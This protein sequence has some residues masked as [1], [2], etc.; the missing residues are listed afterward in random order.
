MR[1]FSLFMRLFTC[2]CLLAFFS[3]SPPLASSSIPEGKDPEAL[4]KSLARI[5]FDLQHVLSVR[6][7]SL[8]RDPFTITFDRGH[9]IFL[10]PVDDLVTGLYF[11]GSGMIVGIPPTKTERQQLNVFT[12]APVLNEHFHEALIRFSDNTYSELMGQLETGSNSLESQLNLS[13]ELLQAALKG[14]SLT[15]YRIV[16]DL[17][18]GRKAPLFL[19]KIFGARLGAFDFS[20]DWRKPESVSLGQVHRT[21]GLLYYDSWGS[22]WQGVLRPDLSSRPRPDLSVRPRE[23]KTIDVL[24]YQIDTQIDKQ[25]RI[26]GSTEVEFKPEQEG[27]WLLS[28][29]LARSLKVSEVMD[30]EQRALTFYQN[31][32]MSNEEEVSKLGHD[33]I[34][35]LLKRPLQ[36]G[37]IRRLKF[38]YSGE[39]LSRMGNGVFYVGA[40]GSWYPNTGLS[41]RARYVLSFQYPKAYTIVATGDFT[42]EWEEGD[43]RHALWESRSEL[44]VAGFNYGDYVKKTA[45]AGRIPVEVYANRGIENVY[46]EVMARQEQIR[47][48]YRQ[49]QAS[50]RLGGEPLQGFTAAAPDFSDFDTTR[51]SDEVT[52]QVVRAL[53]FF[54]PILG[55]FPFSRL[56]VSQIPGKFSQG[57][58][59]LLYVSSLSFLRPEQRE[60]LGIGNDQEANFLECLHAHEIAH[61]WWGNQVSWKSYHDLWMFEGFSNYLAYLFMKEKHPDG[62]QFRDLMRSSK[63]KLL[64]KNS[65]GQTYESAGSLWLGT[66]LSSS[67]FPDG[68]SNLIYNKGAWVL[69]MLRYLMQDP[70][71]GSDQNFH[72]LMRNFLATYRGQS[73]STEDFKRMIEENMEKRMDLEGNGKMDWFFSQWV[74]ETGMPTYRLE[75]SLT[76]LKTGQF[77]LKGKI[78]QQNVSEDFVMPVELFGR[79]GPNRV[80]RLA[81]VVVFGNETNFRFTMKAR[82]QK[83]TLDENNE[84]LCENKTL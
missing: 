64:I 9:M 35:V 6:D 72:L 79:F 53:L 13:S 60:R 37:Q 55:D 36:R 23:D 17:M 26:S 24:S 76:T 33:V 66:R 3:L 56:A 73:V 10:R 46:L 70:N 1:P 77:L 32:D 71:S 44:S 40:R 69:H 51:F 31:S 27:E 82:P 48:F 11:W 39:V 5:E 62:K 2:S 75:S 34:L 57:W 16:A 63:E 83:V 81:R 54:E 22:F 61:Q 7:L 65:E 43:Q 42:K 67:K 59:S 15:H 38:L 19:A 41:D 45:L 4:L 80:E 68:Y 18:N 12:G 25:D 20:V 29:D 52:R 50:P 47:E 14:S 30:E 49:R 58:P 28:F 21:G 74:Y 8:R 78:K 84:I